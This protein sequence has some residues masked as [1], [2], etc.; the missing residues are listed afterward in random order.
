[1]SGALIDALSVPFTDARDEIKEIKK[2][3]RDDGRSLLFLTYQE[4]QKL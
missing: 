4:Q 3:I 2:A 1:M